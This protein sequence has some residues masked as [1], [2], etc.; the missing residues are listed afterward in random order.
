MI[1]GIRNWSQ[2]YQKVSSILKVF[3][4]SAAYNS[5]QLFLVSLIVHQPSCIHNTVT[6]GHQLVLL[7]LKNKHNKFG[8]KMKIL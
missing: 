5:Q 4:V 7:Q 8:L 1:H 2:N 3:Q 6:A